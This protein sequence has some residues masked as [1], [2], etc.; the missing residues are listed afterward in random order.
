MIVCLVSPA[1][2]WGQQWQSAYVLLSNDRCLQ[3]QIE[4]LPDRC[5][6]RQNEGNEITVHRNQ[7]QCVGSSLDDIYRYKLSKLSVG[8]RAGDHFK[9]ARWCLGANLLAEAG[10]HYLRLIKSHPPEAHP[11]V[12]QL[13][14]EIRDMMLRQP[15]LRSHL[16][17]A[18]LPTTHILQRTAGQSAPTST[19]SSHL[20]GVQPASTRPSEARTITSSPANTNSIHHILP[21]VQTRF[22]EQIQHVLL[23]RCGQASC[24]GATSNNSLRLLEIRGVQSAQRSSSNLQSVLQHVSQ[25]PAARSALIEYATRP[26]GWR[27]TAALTHQDTRLIHDLEAWIQLIQ[28]PVVTAEATQLAQSRPAATSTERSDLQ[29]QSALNPLPPGAARLRP[30]PG[31]P[32]SDSKV[33]N[34]EDPFDPSEFNRLRSARSSAPA[35]DS[36][37]MRY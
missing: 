1:V 9:L 15:E 35:T 8:V 3:G 18:P 37:D 25:D 28:N 22:V 23:N 26:H 21:Q 14:V 19:E 13:G 24:H 29:P 12:R 36:A 2:S 27:P 10:E 33:Q 30:V 4:M 16:G 6:I 11:Q 7:V 5:R 20:I 34:A 17:L 31:S 32:S